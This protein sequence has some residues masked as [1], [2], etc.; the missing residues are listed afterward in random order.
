MDENFKVHFDKLIK[1]KHYLLGCSGG[2]DSVALAHLLKSNGFENITICH[3]NYGVR[4]E[5]NLETEYVKQ[6]SKDLFNREARVLYYENGKNL[7]NFEHNARQIRYSFFMSELSKIN[8]CV[9]VLLGHNLNDRMEWMLMQI[10]KGSGLGTI[11][12]FD[13][14][15]VVY[16]MD[17]YRPLMDITKENIY[18]YCHENNIKYFEDKSNQDPKYKRNSYRPFVKEFLKEN[19]KGV[20]NTLLY[21]SKEKEEFYEKV[22]IMKFGDIHYFKRTNKHT[23]LYNINKI[24]KHNYDYLMSNHTS[25]ELEKNKFNIIFPYKSLNTFD[26]MSGKKRSLLYASFNI[27]S[28]EEYTYIHSMAYTDPHNIE[29]NFDKTKEKEFKKF[30]KA[31]K[32]APKLRKHLNS[33]R[34]LFDSNLV[35]DRFSCEQFLKTFK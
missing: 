15:S 30:L 25:K 31:H 19:E 4:E 21:L 10:A 5:A 26:N 9:G 23:D 33:F 32:V 2:A 8:D 28:T 1:S 3:V 34:E 16:G 22:D 6:L 20:R 35:S 24:L 12:G 14:H 17:I 7:T 11:S 29:E 27:V 13:Y 18:E